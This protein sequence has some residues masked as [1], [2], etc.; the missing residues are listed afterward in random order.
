[1]QSLQQEC[2]RTNE[3]LQNFTTG[4][5]EDLKNIHL[6]ISELAKN[7]V[8][9]PR[10]PDQ[11]YGVP[12]RLFSGSS[13]SEQSAKLVSPLASYRADPFTGTSI[14]DRSREIREAE[15]AAAKTLEMERINAFHN[16]ESLSSST[17]TSVGGCRENE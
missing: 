15:A 13:L 5:R 1:M 16:G 11:E 2:R 8:G 9:T 10:D 14:Q 17:T 3:A 4:Y 12:S 6:A 7:S